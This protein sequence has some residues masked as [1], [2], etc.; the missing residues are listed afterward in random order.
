MHHVAETSIAAFHSIKVD[1]E[2][3]TK[4]LLDVYIK[5]GPMSDRQASYKLGWY[6]SQVSAR[7]NALMA[8]KEVVEM[9]NRRDPNTGKTVNVYGIS[10]TT[11]F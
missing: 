1:R 3:Q 10:R 7:R 2:I 6:P 8:L 11:L 5:H 4:Q 9:G